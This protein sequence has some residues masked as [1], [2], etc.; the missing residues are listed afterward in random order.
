MT[1]ELAYN[2]CTSVLFRNAGEAHSQ[3]WFLHSQVNTHHLHGQTTGGNRPNKST[4]ANIWAAGIAIYHSWVT[5]VSLAP[6]ELLSYLTLIPPYK[7]MKRK[8]TSESLRM[9]KRK[10]EKSEL[11]NQNACVISKYF[12]SSFTAGH[13]YFTVNE[14][15]MQSAKLFPNWGISF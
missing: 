11:L 1:W 9:G 4:V 8:S 3:L 2:L 5:T 14:L 13:I 12:A 7:T 10:K 6:L 15:G